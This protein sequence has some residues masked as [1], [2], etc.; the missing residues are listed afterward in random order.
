MTTDEE[1]IKDK[2]RRAH[3]S[4]NRFMWVYAIF[5]FILVLVYSTVLYF[6]NIYESRPWRICNIFFMILGFIILLRDYINVKE[7]DLG[8]MAAFKCCF[9]C[10]VYFCMLFIPLVVIFLSVDTHEIERIQR[11]ET[12][13]SDLTQ[14]EMTFSVFLES[15]TS[16]V[17]AAFV[18]AFKGIR[19]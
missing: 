8:Y 7:E 4:K 14:L 19:H 15:I 18:A 12:F 9:R 13:G 10:G 3:W 16:V 17:I 11:Q 2:K 5:I 6:N 1:N